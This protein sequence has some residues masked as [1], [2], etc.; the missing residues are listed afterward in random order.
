MNKTITDRW[1]EELVMCGHASPIPRRQALEEMI[2]RGWDASEA[3]NAL[4][5]YKQVQPDG[6]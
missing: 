2:L 4:C 6:R 1:L 3:V 5:H